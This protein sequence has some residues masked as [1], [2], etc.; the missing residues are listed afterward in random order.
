LLPLHPNFFIKSIIFFGKREV[1]HK[2][3]GVKKKSS[4][5]WKN[6]NSIILRGGRGK[7]E[8][9][10]GRAL[11]CGVNSVCTKENHVKKD[12]YKLSCGGGEEKKRWGKSCRFGG[13][14]GK[15][16]GGFFQVSR[17]ELGRQVE[18]E[19]RKGDLSRKE[20]KKAN[21]R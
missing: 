21:P 5:L 2:G 6:P 14:R 1:P 11:S 16:G 4:C 19:K 10:R 9:T 7:K 8:K 15:E 20:G 13:E 3:K 18:K 17:G 12:H